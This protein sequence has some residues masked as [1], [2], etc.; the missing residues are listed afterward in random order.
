M[1][2]EIFNLNINLKL[3]ILPILYI[4]IGI[5]LYKII[6][7]IV[8]KIEENSKFNN[9]IDSKKIA[10]IKILG[11]NISK[12]LIVT[13]VI[14]AILSVFGVNVTS[15]VAGIGITAALIGFA[16]Q[17]TAKDFIAGIFILTEEQYKLGD[18]IEIDGFLGEVVFVGLKSTRIKNYRGMVKIIANRN[19]TN[20]INYSIENSLAEIDINISNKYAPEEIDAILIDIKK[21][22]KENDKI[23]GDLEIWGIE[24]LK[25]SGYVY[26]LAIEVKSME[27]YEIQRLI[28]KIIR[29]KFVENNIE[30]Y[31]LVQ[32]DKYGAK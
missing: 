24:E 12:Y 6:K 32:G 25:E 22:I 15:I 27:H 28:R 18:Y 16:M 13:I 8:N 3:I 21:E 17:D 10:T 31:Y 19:I 23:V 14:L 5:I 11:I 2:L 29:Q 1:E 9:K 26:R 4:L 30:F 20:V 7:K